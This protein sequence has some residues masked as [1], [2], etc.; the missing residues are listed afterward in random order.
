[1]NFKAN[2]RHTWILV[3]ALTVFMA[4]LMIGPARQDSATVDETTFLTAGYSYLTGHR[5]YLVP[6][7]SPLGQ[8]LPALPLLV[9]D[10]NLSEQVKALTE[11]RVGY[12]WAVRWKGEPG[13]IAQLF[14]EGRNDWYFIP[15]PESQIAGQMFVYDGTNDGDAMMFAGRF[16]QILLTLGVGI[17]IFV[18]IRQ[19]TRHD[20]FALLGMALW[21][22]NPHALA[23]GHLII[24]DTSGTI[25]IVAALYTFGLLLEKPS[26]RQAV[27]CG[28][29]T[30]LALLLKYTSMI[31]APMYLVLALIYR[32]NLQ[33]AEIKWWKLGLVLVGSFWATILLGY[34]PHWSSPPPIS[35][36]QAHLLGVP[37]W[38][39]VF[40]PLLIPADFFKVLAL[41]LAQSSWGHDG[42]LMGEWSTKGWWYYFPL[43]I[44]LKSPVAFI[45]AII[46]A[47]ALTLN[48][49]RSM[50]P[51]ELVPWVGAALF[52][53]A[54]MTSRV[55]VGVRHLLPMIP[56]LCIGIACAARY[57]TNDTYRKI[58]Y[59][60]I[61]WQTIV[62]VWAYPLYLQYY[63]E[64]VGGAKNGYKHL[65]DSN[66]DW[67]QDAK[68]LKRYLDERGINHI[69][70]NYFGTQYS[71]DYLRIPNTRVTPEQARQIKHGVLVVSASELMRPGWD[72]LRESKQ[73]VE[74]VAHTLFVYQFP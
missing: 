37:G 30:G 1:M 51:L 24:T 66:Y 59:A 50:S 31:L 63:S 71:I 57:A 65:I 36:G 73:P 67:G 70:L 55:N 27:I 3:L 48:R 17:F 52:L 41:K 29:V 60:L 2:S 69:Y 34:F 62:T 35:D 23:Y 33:Q 10:I 72:W 21:V 16:V 9:M 6:D 12:Q 58:I 38:F 8:M 4:V 53:G 43:A 44:V 26:S 74:R 40:R 54:S 5:H 45:A 13:G 68:R 39:L 15:T 20:W 7:H 11:R 64:L 47:V 14:P 28:V 61:G 49:F 19:I 56:L 25:G 32:R 18:W 22:F 46:M 42:Y